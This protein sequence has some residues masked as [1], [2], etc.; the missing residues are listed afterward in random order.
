MAV[1]GTHP[2]AIDILISLSKFSIHAAKVLAR[3]EGRAV[4]AAEME[5][6]LLHLKVKMV[7]SNVLLS[8]KCVNY[9]NSMTIHYDTLYLIGS[10]HICEIIINPRDEICAAASQAKNGDITCTVY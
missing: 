4:A 5:F 1:Y 10:M 7:V 2:L 8:L 3:T 6:V 9:L